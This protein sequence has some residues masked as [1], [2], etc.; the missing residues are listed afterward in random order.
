MST[1]QILGGVGGAVGF[2]F[3]GARGAQWGYMLGSL[4]GSIIDPQRIRGPSIGDGQ[5]QLSQDGA[6][7]N[8]VYG[9]MVV[10]GTV[11]DPGKLTKVIVKEQQ[12]K[13]GP[14]VEHAFAAPWIDRVAEVYRP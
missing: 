8:I 6:P 3:G 14:V 5:T 12:G 11:C 1:S 9:T 2:Y 13:G 7:I 4:A 10:I